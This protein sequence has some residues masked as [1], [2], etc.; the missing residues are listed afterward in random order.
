MK[1]GSLD[2]FLDCL[3]FAPVGVIDLIK[4]YAVALPLND[5]NKRKAIKDKLGYDIDA[6]IKNDQATKDAE[7]AATEAATPARRVT[8]PVEQ[9]TVAE[10]PVRR[11]KPKYTIPNQQ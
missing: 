2:E 7:K 10:G 6:A 5:H 8:K 1:E 11:T 4:R 3:D 9:E